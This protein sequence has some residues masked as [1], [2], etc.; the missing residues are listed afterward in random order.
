MGRERVRIDP[1][2]A[3]TTTTTYDELSR[4]SEV[5][6]RLNRTIAYAYDDGNRLATEIWKNNAAVT[7]NVITYAYD[8]NNNR[9]SV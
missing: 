2:G 6:D 9:T 3:R 4:V 8:V 1:L 5:Q 7:L